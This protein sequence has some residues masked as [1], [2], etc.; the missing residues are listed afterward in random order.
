VEGDIEAETFI[1]P[2]QKGRAMARGGRC[3]SRQKSVRPWTTGMDIT[4]MRG[5]RRTG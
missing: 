5:H 2:A 4:W 3:W 1:L